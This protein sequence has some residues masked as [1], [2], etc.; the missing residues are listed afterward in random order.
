MSLF[1]SSSDRIDA[2]Q[3]AVE[4]VPAA[5]AGIQGRVLRN[6]VE[7]AL[8]AQ[9]PRVTAH[10]AKIRTKEPDATPEQVI[11]ALDRR[12]QF[13]VAGLG[14]V[15]GG[16]AIFPAIG[17]AVSLATAAAEAAAAL[18]AAVLYTLAVAEVHSMH[19]DDVERRRA[20]VLGIVMGAGGTELMR[21]VTGGKDRWARTVTEALPLRVLGPVNTT[22]GRWFVKRYVTRQLALA[23]G[24]ALP[25]GIG[26][27]IGGVGNVVAA[28][29]VI[30]AAGRAFGPPPARWPEEPAIAAPRG[31]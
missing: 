15:G 9:H 23:V 14:A 13:A 25:F 8:R 11:A 5:P 20:L 7:R 26:V 16:I 1:R 30:S 19:I 22:L 4:S 31:A 18:D 6:V 29:T 24:R 17:T 28:R 10:I 27:I 12:Y 3:P 2:G 21:K